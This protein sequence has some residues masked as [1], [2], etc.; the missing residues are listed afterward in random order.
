MAQNQAAYA[1]SLG[2]SISTIYYSGNTPANQQASYAAS[3]ATL[4]GGTGISLVVPT[5][6]Q[7]SSSFAAFCAT[8]AS[9]L[10]LVN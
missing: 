2:I 4:T 3:L 5:T 8:M 7:I 10:K 1:R 6:G 9:A